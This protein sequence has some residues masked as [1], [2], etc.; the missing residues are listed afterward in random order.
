MRAKRCC[1]V[2]LLLF[3]LLGG[4]GCS[5]DLPEPESQAAQLYT[6]HCSGCHRLYHPQLLTADMWAFMLTRMDEEFQRLGRP[7][8]QGQ[9]RQ[10][11]L[12]YLQKHSGKS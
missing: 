6:R 2:I 3:M 5:P 11:L 9:E 8:L 12:E 10:S 1:P 7:A 4:G